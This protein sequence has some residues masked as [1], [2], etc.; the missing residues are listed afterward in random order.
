MNYKELVLAAI[1]HQP[2]QSLPFDVYEGWMWP[3]IKSR[4]IKRFGLNHYEELLIHFGVYCRWVEAMYVGPPLPEGANGRVAS[5]HTTHSLNFCIWGLEPGLR[6]H[7]LRSS[8]HPLSHVQSE[9]DI[10]EYPWPS[11][12]WFDYKELNQRAHQ[13]K[14]YFVV[15]G[16]F[17]PIFYLIA[18]LCG[19]EKTLMDM[20]TNPEV[21]KSLVYKISEFYEGYFSRIAET[22][23]G[24][25]DAIAF[26]DDFSGQLAMLFSPQFWREYFR[27]A[28]AKL[29]SIAKKYGYKV[30]FHSC[31]SVHKVIP[32]LVEIGLD[33]L[34]PIQT[35]AASMDISKLHHE[36]GKHLAFYGAIDVQ[37]LLAF[38]TPHEIERE[39]SRI[40]QVFEREGG[41]ILSTSHVI[42]DDVPEENVLALYK[43]VRNIY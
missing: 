40:A 5:P 24:N 11:P 2:I 22:C 4:L 29:F 43:A 17:S 42:M 27:D 33:V 16:G 36:F 10:L 26:G 1:E 15:V 41:Y 30:M 39:V 25:V 35:Q 3:D 20:V 8:G 28:W 18:D 21:I 32:D 14:D 19:M 12:D 6:E 37:Q 13:Y 9:K 7:G 34:Y 23:V 31:G 38:G